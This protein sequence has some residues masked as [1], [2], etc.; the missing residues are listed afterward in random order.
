MDT[1]GSG[2]IGKDELKEALS[3]SAGAEISDEQIDQLIKFADKD[4]D[5]QISFEEYETIMNI[6]SG[7]SV[8]SGQPAQ[9]QGTAKPT[10]VVVAEDGVQMAICGG[11]LTLELGSKMK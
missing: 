3:K 8:S 9:S 11:A 1:D 6:K 4:G 7:V 2:F 5:G 10:T